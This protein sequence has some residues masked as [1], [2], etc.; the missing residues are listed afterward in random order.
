M[1]KQT[2]MLINNKIDHLDNK[3]ANLD[4]QT[5]DLD[6]RVDNIEVAVKQMKESIVILQNKIED[7]N[8]TAMDSF[9]AHKTHIGKFS[10]T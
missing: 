10:L 6:D 8:K 1:V 9:A 2:E 4:A 3:T 5:A 7:A